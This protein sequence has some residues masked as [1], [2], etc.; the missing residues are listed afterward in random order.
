[1]E[2]RYKVKV[3]SKGLVVIPAEIRRRLGIVEGSYLDLIV[4]GKK[5]YIIVPSSLREAYGIDGEKALKVAKL[6]SE[7]RR[8]E[9]E[10]EVHS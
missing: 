10:G 7:S 6:I 8:M 5:I 2:A 9:V 4:E 1:M 3:H